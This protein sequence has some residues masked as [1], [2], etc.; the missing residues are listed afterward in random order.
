MQI[1]YNSWT[2]ISHT[3]STI[4]Q[5]IY[6]IE[7][8]KLFANEIY[9]ICI[10]YLILCSC[11]KELCQDILWPR[12]NELN[13]SSPWQSW[14]RADSVPTHHTLNFTTE[15][16]TGHTKPRTTWQATTTLLNKETGEN[17]ATN[18]GNYMKI[19]LLWT[20]TCIMN[21]H[22]SIHCQRLEFR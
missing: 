9:N 16:G 6:I 13:I 2:G 20:A 22:V 4:E 18:K 11:N 8:L 17:S 21:I 10:C 5:H 12:G 7:Y 19:H 14:H 15:S 3:D 1:F